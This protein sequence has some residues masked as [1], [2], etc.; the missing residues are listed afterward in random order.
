MTVSGRSVTVNDRTVTVSDRNMTVSDRN[1]ALMN[2]DDI[3]TFCLFVYFNFLTPGN[4]KA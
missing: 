3:I 4:L 2:V 1:I